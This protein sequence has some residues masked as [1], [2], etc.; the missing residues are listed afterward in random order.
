MALSKSEE[1]ILQ[2]IVV[3]SDNDPERPEFPPPEPKVSRNPN[4]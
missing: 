1:R 3:A 2:S 4:R